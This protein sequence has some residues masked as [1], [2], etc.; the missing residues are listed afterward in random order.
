MHTQAYTYT[1]NNNYVTTVAPMSLGTKLKVTSIQRVN[2]FPSRE[3][4]PV[5]VIII[6]IHVLLA[7]QLSWIHNNNKIQLT[8]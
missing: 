2:R 3:T 4:N 7:S 6:I 5:T 8:H 1:S